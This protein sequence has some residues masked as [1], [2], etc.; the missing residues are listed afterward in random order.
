[1]ADAYGVSLAF[2]GVLAAAAVATHALMQLPAG[3]LID[4]Y[5]ARGAAAGGS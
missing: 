1:M 2:V 3:R 5:G 4:R